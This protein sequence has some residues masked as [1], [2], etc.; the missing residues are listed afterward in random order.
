M[1]QAQSTTVTDADVRRHQKTFYEELIGMMRAHVV[2]LDAE[3]SVE[4]V[5]N[6][7]EPGLIEATELALEDAR[8]TEMIA[9]ARAANAGRRLV[10]IQDKQRKS[11]AL[12]L[13]DLFDALRNGG[14]IDGALLLRGHPGF[15]GLTDDPS[16]CGLFGADMGGGDDL[17]LFSNAR[18]AGR[19][20]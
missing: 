7:E 13:G 9:T 12:G 2:V 3:Q 6:S 1:Q 16:G 18:G 5:S 8:D 4:D 20:G 15:G 14:L 11:G 17:R 19:W 10:R